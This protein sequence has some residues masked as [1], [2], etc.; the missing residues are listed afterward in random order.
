MKVNIFK[1]LIREVIREELDYKFSALE[2][3]LDEVVVKS[4]VSNIN[5]ARTQ[6]PQSTDFKKLMN[7]SVNTNPKA[8]TPQSNISAPKTSNNVLNDLLQET[9]F[10]DIVFDFDTWHCKDY[11]CKIYTNV[12]VLNFPGTHDWFWFLS[13]PDNDLAT[14]KDNFDKYPV[15]HIDLEVGI[16]K[17]EYN[18]DESLLFP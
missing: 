3:K 8:S 4:N 5:E 13:I 6:V 11:N 12:F 7:D 16:C 18:L 17:K 10:L 15:Y 14:Y 2:K 9:D 1:K